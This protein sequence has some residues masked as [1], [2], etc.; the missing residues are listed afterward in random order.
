M[1]VLGLLSLGAIGLALVLPIPMPALPPNEPAPTDTAPNPDQ[2]KAQEE[3]RVQPQEWSALVS[4]LDSLREHTP[5][6]AETAPPQGEEPTEAAPAPVPSTPPLA[7]RYA[8][9]IQG[10]GSI[11]ALVGTPYGQ[12]LIFEGQEFTDD[13]IPGAK[14]IVKAITAEYLLIDRSGKE[15]RLSFSPPDPPGMAGRI[16][17]SSIRR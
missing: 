3:A 1:P 4:A 15:E 14:M 7:W 17:S 16:P 10:P 5:E 6:I 9:R 8:G 12:K 2:E 11:A 13:A